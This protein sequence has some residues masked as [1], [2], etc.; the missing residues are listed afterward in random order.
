MFTKV[1]SIPALLMCAWMAAKSASEIVGV[2]IVLNLGVPGRFTL[3]E[4]LMYLI[5]NA[6][7]LSIASSI[8]KRL[9]VYEC[10]ASFQPSFSAGV[11]P[12]EAW[13]ARDWEKKAIT[14]VIRAIGTNLCMRCC[15]RKR[16]AMFNDAQKSPWLSRGL[17]T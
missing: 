12:V 7:V 3:P 1:G 11:W 8:E 4:M 6:A 13:S 16:R 14:Q 10:I 15:N 17:A 9:R 2:G 5:P